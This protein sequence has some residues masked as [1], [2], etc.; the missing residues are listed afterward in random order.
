MSERTRED[1]GANR[2]VAIVLF[3]LAGILLATAAATVLVKA[4]NTAANPDKRPACLKQTGLCDSLVR[5]PAADKY[6]KAYSL[7]PSDDSGN[8]SRSFYSPP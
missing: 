5:M 8:P 3:V 4:M 7:L 1:R 6:R 2:I